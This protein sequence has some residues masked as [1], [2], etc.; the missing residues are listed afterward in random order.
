MK[1]RSLH[2]AFVIGSM[3]VGGA[4]RATLNLINGL[5]ENGIK[6][7]L[8]LLSAEGELINE[9]SK[10]INVV[11]LNKSRTIYSVNAFRN[12]LKKNNPEIIVAVQNHIQ[13]LVML[14]MKFSDWNGK[15]ILNEQ[16][17]YSKNVRGV[18]G[19]LQKLLSNY[20]F[21]QAEAITLV[22]EGVKLDFAKSFPS[23]RKKNIVIP[24]GVITNKF[25]EYKKHSVNHHFFDESKKVVVAAGRLVK[26]KNFALLL[27]AF[28]LAKKKI[29]IKLILLGLGPE[30]FSLQQLAIKLKISDD[31]SFQGYVSHPCQYFSRADVFVLSSDYEGL[32]SVMIEAM[33][34]GCKIVSTN[35]ENGPAEIL[36]NGEY[37]W[38]VPVGDVNALSSAIKTAL[39]T[40]IDS[41]KL[42]ERANH[43][44]LNKVVEQ[45]ESLFSELISVNYQL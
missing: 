4:E 3:R 2:I 7:D 16:S 26:S 38:L 23:V 22:S 11:S 25:E 14:S 42:I 39:K 5:S 12:Y 15:I 43:F 45:Y 6:I 35:C 27:N 19:G 9:I 20:L 28:A 30:L 31:V 1:A 17:T 21:Q 37:G 24:N 44:H 36:V 32:P 40:E 18:K 29:D 13:L 34:C 10:S 33:A 41:S 8:V